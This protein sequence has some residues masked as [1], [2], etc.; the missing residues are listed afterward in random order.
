VAGI[1]GG[2]WLL[3]TPPPAAGATSLTVALSVS[4]GMLVLGGAF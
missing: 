4:P 1:V 2:V 3:S